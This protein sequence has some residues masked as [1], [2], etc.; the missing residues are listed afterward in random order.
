MPD[1]VLGPRYTAENTNLKCTDHESK[2]VEW[3]SRLTLY[4]TNEESGIA[5][6]LGIVVRDKKF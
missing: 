5:H 1:T 2:V 3:Y 6:L 4:F